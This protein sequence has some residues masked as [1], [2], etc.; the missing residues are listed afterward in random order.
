MGEHRNTER[1]GF[2]R[3]KKKGRWETLKREGAGKEV[4]GIERAGFW[5]RGEG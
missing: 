2:W 5:K 3:G 1:G 4:R